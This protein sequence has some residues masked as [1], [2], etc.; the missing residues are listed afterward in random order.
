MTHIER[1]RPD[2]GNRKATQGVALREFLHTLCL[3]SNKVELV[4]VFLVWPGVGL[5]AD[6]R[7]H[8]MDQWV[9]SQPPL[10]MHC[11]SLWGVYMTPGHTTLQSPG[12]PAVLLKVMTYRNQ[13]CSPHS[14]GACLCLNPRTGG[15]ATV[16][17][18]SQ[19]PTRDA[20]WPMTLASLARCAPPELP[21]SR[22][23]REISS[24][25]RP[26]GKVSGKNR[27]ERA[28][29]SLCRRACGGHQL[30]L[31]PIYADGG[32]GQGGEGPGQGHV[33][34]HAN[35]G[36]NGVPQLPKP[37]SSLTCTSH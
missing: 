16:R 30:Q 23:A 13:V 5:L 24:G 2:A 1:G 22:P 19:F 20:N 6:K 7:M 11:Q 8:L 3:K 36:E 33:V 34:I 27:P 25:H 28:R 9:L 14:L 17:V 35:L 31:C 18:Q 12:L 32:W 10:H 37:H 4:L 15:R 21:G 26:L 29:D